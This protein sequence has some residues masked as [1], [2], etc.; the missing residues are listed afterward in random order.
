MHK[1]ALG[2]LNQALATR[3]RTR[4]L[5]SDLQREMA[6]GEEAKGPGCKVRGS[7][8][9]RSPDA[10]LR[11]PLHLADAVARLATQTPSRA[12]EWQNR[13]SLPAGPH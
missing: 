10:G 8:V 2:D 7:R 9:R 11:L 3:G 12:Q 4:G 1:E 5:G 13:P 6:P